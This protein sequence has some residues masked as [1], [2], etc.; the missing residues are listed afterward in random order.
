MDF[1]IPPADNR[2]NYNPRS[3]TGSCHL[4]RAHLATPEEIAERRNLAFNPYDC[5][6]NHGEAVFAARNAVDGIYE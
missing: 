1:P 6:G 5:H 2:I 3:F 4:L